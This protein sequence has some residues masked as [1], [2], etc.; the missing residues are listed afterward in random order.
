MVVVAFIQN[1]GFVVSEWTAYPS[2][3]SVETSLNLHVSSWFK[4]TWV[5]SLLLREVP[6][7]SL[8]H[9]NKLF[10]DVSIDGEVEILQVSPT[11]T[12]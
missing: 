4:M 10:I 2:L 1:H 3:V 6:K 11:N 7:I 8:T 12:T 9:D 5:H